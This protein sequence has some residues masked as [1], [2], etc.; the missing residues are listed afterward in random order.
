MDKKITDNKKISIDEV[1]HIAELAKIELSTEEMEKFSSELSDVLGYVGQL[2]KVDTREIEPVSQVTG[3]V[4]VL[5]KDVIKSTDE[6]TR[7]RMIDNFPDKDDDHI[8]VKQI[9]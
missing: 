1:R 4:N 8:K 6:D 2:E 7:K 9:M 3:L 5:R